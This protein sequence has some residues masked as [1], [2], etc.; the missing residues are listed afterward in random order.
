MSDSIF[1][2]RGTDRVSFRLDVVKKTFDGR[3]RRDC[4][5]RFGHW[6]CRWSRFFNNLKIKSFFLLNFNFHAG[7]VW[8]LKKTRTFLYLRM[9]PILREISLSLIR[10]F[11]SS[12]AVILSAGFSFHVECDL[13]ESVQERLGNLIQR[14]FSNTNLVLLPKLCDR[15]KIWIKNFYFWKILN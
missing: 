5:W 3:C 10:P 14:T 15:L 13:N 11:V 7:G 6:G 1:Q 4:W 9:F 2:P 8:Y 12:P